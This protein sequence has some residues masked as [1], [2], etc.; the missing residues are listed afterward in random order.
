MI[1]PAP[2]LLI[3]G[4]CLQAAAGLAQGSVDLVY[5]DPPFFTGR[6]RGTGG[7]VGFAD[8][9]PGGLR[10]YLRWLT[11]RL[12]AAAR[13]MSETG[14]MYVHLDWHAVHYVKVELDRML[15]YES[16]LNEVIWLYGLGGS[17]P[18]YWPR[19]H[20]N[21][22]WYAREPGRHYF[23]AAR[24]PATSRRMAGQTKKAPDYWDIPALN[25]MSRERR[26]YPTQK[27][28]ALLERIVESS[29]PPGGVVADLFCGSGTTAAVAQRTGR[30]WIACDAS[31]EAVAL[32]R[33]RVAELGA[34]F[35]QSCA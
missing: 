10:S 1:A 2:S 19:K 16:F 35:A 6:D 3:H 26:A 24:V 13:L 28:E 33:E 4:D 22:L 21:I 12:E 31:G 14:S 8:R 27:P 32:T 17:S 15:G 20:D 34:A 7:Q 25:N 30:R 9:W 18:R 23:E 29:C 11:P 5:L